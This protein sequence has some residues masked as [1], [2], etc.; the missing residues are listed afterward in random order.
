MRRCTELGKP[1]LLLG[2]F[3]ARTSSL[4]DYIV[5]DLDNDM[6]TEIEDEMIE[7]LI[8]ISKLE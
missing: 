4:P 7:F 3:N 2:D 5:V 6:L 8:D 1:I